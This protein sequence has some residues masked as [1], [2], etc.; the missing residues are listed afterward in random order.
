MANNNRLFSNIKK[1]FY[2]ILS[3]SLVLL[4]IGIYGILLLFGQ[5][6]INSLKENLEIIVELESNTSTTDHKT[7]QKYLQNQPY[8]KA[9][10]VKFISKE[11]GLEKLSKQFGDDLI[12]FEF[13]N[14]L[15]DVIV[16]H[17]TNDFA[18]SEK[19]KQIKLELLEETK[20]HD[21]HY[22]EVIIANIEHN[23]KQLTWVV[24][25]IGGLFLLIAVALINN[26]VRLALNDNRFLIKNMQYVGATE[27]FI[28]K[29]YLGKAIVN[30][31][32][33]STLAITAILG[34]LYLIQRR[35][36]DLFPNNFLSFNLLMLFVILGLIGIII[37]SSST[38]FAVRRFL[39]K[40]VAEL[41]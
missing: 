17:V 34:I 14:P 18:E 21:I 29:P 31:F 4:I 38:F 41:Y 11:K 20:I 36:P 40:P 7:L 6:T 13:E 2:A 22:Q 5:Q 12:D 25:V 24:F 9:K 30:G 15:F 33:S 16:F 10:T 1:Y 3:T 37:S 32:V 8:T 28:I 27:T 23:S 35:V 26:T 39:R 19:L